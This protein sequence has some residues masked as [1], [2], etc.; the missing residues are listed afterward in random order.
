MLKSP[1]AYRE[2]WGRS[3]LTSSPLGLR[4][5]ATCTQP[6]T[7]WQL[8]IERVR[9]NSKTITYMRPSREQEV[10]HFQWLADL[11]NVDAQRAVGQ[12]FNQHGVTQDPAQALRYFR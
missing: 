11:G 2:P 1:E 10:L 3:E 7:P 4:L 5:H 12:M 9:L 6:P 8:Q